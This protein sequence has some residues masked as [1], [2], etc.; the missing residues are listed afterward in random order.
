MLEPLFCVLERDG[1]FTFPFGDNG[2]VMEVFQQ[3]LVILDRQH[4]LSLPTFV[5]ND[6]LSREIQAFELAPSRPIIRDD[7]SGHGLQPNVKFSP[8]GP[9]HQ[10]NNARSARAGPLQRV[11]GSAEVICRAVSRW[12]RLL[13][14]SFNLVPSRKLDGGSYA[15]RPR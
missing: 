4:D 5:V 12:P 6:K 10:T 3:L 2:Q 7:A 1:F 14:R 13:H 9:H 8:P 15:S 11:L